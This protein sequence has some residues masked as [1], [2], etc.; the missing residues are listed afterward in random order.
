MCCTAAVLKH[1]MQFGEIL[2]GV[3]A[4]TGEEFRRIFET[5]LRAFHALPLSLVN[6]ALTSPAVG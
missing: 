5:A 4:G 1:N 6:L 3:A 2:F